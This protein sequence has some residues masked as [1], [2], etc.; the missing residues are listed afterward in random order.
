MRRI[1]NRAMLVA[2]ERGRFGYISSVGV[3]EPNL[4][5]FGEAK[6]VESLVA[7]YDSLTDTDNAEPAYGLGDLV[8]S[9]V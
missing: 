1:E 7:Q 8:H 3:T 6:L 5:R 9:G 4:F 2:G